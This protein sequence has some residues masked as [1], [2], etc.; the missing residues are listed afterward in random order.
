MPKALYRVV[1]YRVCGERAVR[2]D[3]LE[4]LADLIRPALAWRSG[5]PAPKPP[6]AVEGGG[7][8][9]TVNMTSLTG[10]SGEDFASILR[11]LGYR[12]DKRVKPAEPPPAPA[13]RTPRP[14]EAAPATSLPPRKR[15][16]RRDCRGD[17][18]RATD[19]AF[20]AEA[21]PETVRG[22][23]AQVRPSGT[24][25][26][27]P[28]RRTR[29]SAAE[30]VDGRPEWPK[31]RPNA[32]EAPAEEKPAEPEMIEIWRPG[33]PPEERRRTRPHPQG[34][35]RERRAPAASA[36]AP[37]PPRTAGAAAPQRRRAPAEADASAAPSAKQSR[38]ERPRHG[39]DRPPSA[40][41]VRSARGG[42]SSA[43]G[44]A[45]SGRSAGPRTERPRAR[46]GATSRIAT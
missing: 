28:R 14:T 3:I 19:A 7:F 40:R 25:A 33:R 24:D 45:A 37:Q 46:A 4:R 35:R 18:S 11:S 16:R 17:G 41:I 42:R 43:S 26:R 30:A 31:P 27:R 29:A 12:M 23:A 13:G 15:R 6:G 22:R 8:T 1:G 38:D 9:V 2:V 20:R 32:A 21:A 34:E 36:A 39:R 44:V 5:S 10:S